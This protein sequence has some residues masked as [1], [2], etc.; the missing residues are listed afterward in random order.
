MADS[1]SELSSDMDNGKDYYD[2]LVDITHAS[3][4][5]VPGCLNGALVDILHLPPKFM[6][7]QGNLL[8]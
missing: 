6:Q 3:E 4:V 2:G 5:R 7:P 8:E 1:C